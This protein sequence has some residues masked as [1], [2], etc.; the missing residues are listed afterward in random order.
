MVLAVFV[1]GTLLFLA[2]ASHSIST[3][4]AE[5]QHRAAAAKDCPPP[6]PVECTCAPCAELACAPCPPPARLENARRDSD[7]ENSQVARLTADNLKLREGLGAM[8]R[9]LL[10]YCTHLAP[11]VGS[12]NLSSSR[13][14]VL[15][16]AMRAVRG[17]RATRTT[18]WR[19]TA[20]TLCAPALSSGPDG[21]IWRLSGPSLSS[22]TCLALIRVVCE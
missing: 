2:A 1:V 9:P 8:C 19:R 4:L 16:I 5:R 21:P 20:P 11:F 15:V 18:S 13:S 10:R 14:G 7:D 17:S 3:N 6:A 12:Q 22:R